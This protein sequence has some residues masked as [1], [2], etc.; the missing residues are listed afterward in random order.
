MSASLTIGQLSQA[1]QVPAKTIRYYEE[2]KLLPEAKRSNN[3]YRTYEERDV[4]LLK[5]I[6]RS[7][8]LG[9]SVEKVGYLLALWNNPQ[10]RSRDVKKM[11]HTHVAQIESKISQLE[12]LRE[13]LNDLVKHCHGDDA[14]DCPILQD[15]EGLSS[16]GDEERG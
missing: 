4:H 14:P 6:K 10:R 8:D 16:A 15:L 11:V 2:T 3:G 1:T 7:R 9:F 5:F 13:T 12:G